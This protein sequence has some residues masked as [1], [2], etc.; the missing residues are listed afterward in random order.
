VQSL[1][2]DEADDDADV[3]LVRAQAKVSALH[4]AT[5]CSLSICGCGL[6]CGF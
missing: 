6:Y 1:C 5:V 2:P 3:D 4:L